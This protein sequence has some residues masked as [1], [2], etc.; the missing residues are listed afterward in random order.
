MAIHVM[1]AIF[2]KAIESYGRPFSAPTRAAGARAFADEVNRAGSEMNRHPQDYVLY[3]VGHFDDSSGRFES[4]NTPF[5]LFP[6]K[7]VLNKE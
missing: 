1:L 3:E 2:D 4:L 6:A 7:D 5:G